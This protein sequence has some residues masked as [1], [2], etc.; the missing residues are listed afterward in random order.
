M[1][2][3]ERFA[4]WWDATPVT[5]RSIWVGGPYINLDCL[6]PYSQAK[7]A[8]S[9][10]ILDC[11]TVQDASDGRAVPT[12]YDAYVAHRADTGPT[13]SRRYY[14]SFDLRDF[15]A[16]HPEANTL[17]VHINNDADAQRQVFSI[18]IP[19]RAD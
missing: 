9:F 12:E 10:F 3:P 16:N 19:R 7:R 14:L 5:V 2:E 1:A 13:F 11:E 15:I 18:N 4:G 17:R 6:L 8:L